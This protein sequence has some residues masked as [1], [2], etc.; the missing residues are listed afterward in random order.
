LQD[1]DSIN[2]LAILLAKQEKFDEALKLLEKCQF[3]DG[4]VNKGIIY[5]KKA[6]SESIRKAEEAYLK[7]ID[8]DF[9]KPTAHKNL[10]NVYLRAQHYAEAMRCYKQAIA[11]N[12]PKTEDI[13]IIIDD[14][15]TAL[16]GGEYS[17]GYN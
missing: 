16:R 1:V 2:E 9:T 6:D 12:H 17:M 3:Y 5:E 4:F 13:H 14:I 10:G 15:E 7:A 11:L 8:L